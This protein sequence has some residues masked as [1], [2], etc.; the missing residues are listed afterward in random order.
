MSSFHG[1]VIS[2]S[3][4]T[5]CA[6]APANEKKWAKQQGYLVGEVAIP[7]ALDGHLIDPAAA[8]ASR[9]KKEERNR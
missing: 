2:V 1:T 9:I 8:W 5:S 6:K 3:I 4:S 7:D